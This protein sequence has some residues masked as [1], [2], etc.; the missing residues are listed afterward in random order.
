[1][2][3][4]L[5]KFKVSHISLDHDLG[6]DERLG[7]GYTVVCWVEEKV[8]KDDTYNPPYIG[9]HSQNTVGVLN[10]R[11]GISS[12]GQMLSKRPRQ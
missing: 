8:F 7:T 3:D 9:V 10:M 6:D 12:I 1:M 5:K 11:A 4:M 2:I